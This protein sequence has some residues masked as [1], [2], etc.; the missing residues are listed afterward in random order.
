VA[1]SVS[2]RRRLFPAAYIGEAGPSGRRW[3]SQN[4]WWSR[5]VRRRPAFVPG[6]GCGCSHRAPRGGAGRGR[7]TVAACESAGRVLDWGRAV[8]DETMTRRNRRKEK[9]DE[10]RRPRGTGLRPR[11]RRPRSARPERRFASSVLQRR[12]RRGSGPSAFQLG[13]RKRS[14][15]FECRRRKRWAALRCRRRGQLFAR[16]CGPWRRRRR[17][18]AVVR[19]SRE[20]GPRSGEVARRP[21]CFRPWVP[22]RRRGSSGDG[23][24]WR[25]GPRLEQPLWR[26]RARRR[27]RARVPAVVR[28]CGLRAE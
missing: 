7:P 1:L 17:V 3:R 27:G 4:G 6:V 19:S 9:T 14:A 21:C 8:P 22:R 13:R 20:L 23:R 12:T 26:H 2:P 18:V 28:W 15:A 11:S 10:Q 5:S 24:A 25:P 16:C